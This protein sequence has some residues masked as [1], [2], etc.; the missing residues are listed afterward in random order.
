MSLTSTGGLKDCPF[1]SY[2]VDNGSQGC[3]YHHDT[4]FQGFDDV[5]RPIHS[6]ELLLEVLPSELVHDPE[7][8]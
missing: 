4:T 6:S 1:D 3:I 8:L 2:L 5:V 7:I